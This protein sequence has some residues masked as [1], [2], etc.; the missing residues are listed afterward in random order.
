MKIEILRNKK[1]NTVLIFVVSFLAIVG[2]SIFISGL[3]ELFT[4]NTV[5]CFNK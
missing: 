1:A 2:L 3:I 5:F 4:G